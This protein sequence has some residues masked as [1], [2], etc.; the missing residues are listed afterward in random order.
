MIVDG[1]RPWPDELLET[2]AGQGYA[3]VHVDDVR[4]V[5]FFV[6]AGGVR[7]VVVDARALQVPGVLALRK[8]REHAPSTSVVVMASEATSPTVKRA[9][10]SGATAFLSWPAPPHQVAQV[11]RSGGA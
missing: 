7:A 8:C 9:L 4:L 3:L 6:L 1:H 5:P 11:L 10:E 2:I